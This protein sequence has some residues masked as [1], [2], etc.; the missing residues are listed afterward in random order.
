MKFSL[1]VI[2]MVFLCISCSSRTAQKSGHDRQHH[3]MPNDFSDAEHWNKVFDSPERD[4]RQM[5]DHVIEIMKIEPGMTVA[6]LGAGTGYFLPYLSKAAGENGGVLALDIEQSLVNYMTE[7]AEKEGLGNVEARVVAPDNPG[8]KPQSV[9]RILIV[10]TW[11]H[12]P[13][14]VEYAKK[15]AAALSTK[16]MLFIVDITMESE[17]GPHEKHRIPPKKMKE[18][19]EEAGLKA[20][21]ERENLPDQ[22]IVSA[23]LP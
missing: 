12:L 11:H 5:P 7:R 20:T 10:N 6:D 1:I 18:I 3:T 9:D 13:D 23:Q 21:I 16:G 4:A 22:Y 8:L 2:S 15:L 14:Q 19:L 17:V